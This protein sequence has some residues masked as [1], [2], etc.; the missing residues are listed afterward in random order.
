MSLLSWFRKKPDPSPPSVNRE[1]ALRHETWRIITGIQPYTN[2]QNLPLADR[3]VIYKDC[4]DTLN[5]H[6][7][8]VTV[9]NFVQELRDHIDMKLDDIELIK[10]VRS[11]ILVLNELRT[12]LQMNAENLRE[13]PVEPFDQHSPF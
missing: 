4:E 6:G 10:Q 12:R 2:I 11:G 13:K 1:S 8:N 9:D 5:N 3:K 7:F